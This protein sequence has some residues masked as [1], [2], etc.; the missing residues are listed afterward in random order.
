MVLAKSLERLR[1]HGLDLEKIV[2]QHRLFEG[3]VEKRAAPGNG[4]EVR[5]QRERREPR[6]AMRPATMS[7]NGRRSAFPLSNERHP[8]C[9]GRLG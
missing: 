1:K 8:V 2:L 4:P 5:S 3:I 7:K 6:S 9:P